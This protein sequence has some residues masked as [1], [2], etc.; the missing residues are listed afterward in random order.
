MGFSTIS[1]IKIRSML[2]P[3]TQNPE[4]VDPLFKVFGCLNYVFI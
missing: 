4:H 1:I 3:W 2:A